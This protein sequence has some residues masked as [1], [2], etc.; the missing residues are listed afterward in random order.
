MIVW[1]CFALSWALTKPAVNHRHR[2]YCTTTNCKGSNYGKFTWA[3]T[4]NFPAWI[5]TFQLWDICSW[6]VQSVLS[7][8]RSFASETLIHLFCFVF[9]VWLKLTTSFLMWWGTMYF[10]NLH[11]RE[12]AFNFS[13][14][15]LYLLS[16]QLERMATGCNPICFSA[17]HFFTRYPQVQPWHGTSNLPCGTYPKLKTKQKVGSLFTWFVAWRVKPT[18][19]VAF[20]LTS[21]ILTHNPSASGLYVLLNFKIPS[22]INKYLWGAPPPS[23]ID[24]QIA[25]IL[26]RE[27][28]QTFTC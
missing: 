15:F 19:R 4:Q 27:S 2:F 1:V 8:Q 13:L 11:L 12:N 17:T 24:H 14:F 25:F 7:C 3:E 5:S 28:F 21:S 9:F 10:L 20:I 18:V 16:F 23:N 26:S 22:W 6:T